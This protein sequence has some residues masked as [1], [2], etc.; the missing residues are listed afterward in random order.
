MTE[1]I[2]ELY[3]T[4]DIDVN[5]MFT[6]TSAEWLLF[7]MKQLTKLYDVEGLNSN[8]SIPLPF[9]S[10]H[11]SQDSDVSICFSYKSKIVWIYSEYSNYFQEF[12]AINKEIRQFYFGND[13]IDK[14][15]TPEYVSLI[16]DLNIIYGVDKAAKLHALKSKGETFYARLVLPKRLWS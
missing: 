10:L 14:S 11:L 12:R 6:Y 5:T 16:S 3:E 2:E 8:F 7:M 4:Q 1:S 15:K 9:R 13:T